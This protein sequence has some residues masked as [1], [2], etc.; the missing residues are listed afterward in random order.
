[1]T[2]LVAKI[3]KIALQSDGTIHVEYVPENPELDGATAH[4]AD[5]ALDG[6]TPLDRAKAYLPTARAEM[7][8][9]VAVPFPFMYY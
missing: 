3:A 4:G 8:Y 1:M 2:P 9:A 5:L 7:V 6:M